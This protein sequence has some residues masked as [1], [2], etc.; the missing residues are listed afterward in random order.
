MGRGAALGGD[1]AGNPVGV[2]AGDIGW[3]DFGHHQHIGLLGFNL[4]LHTTQLRQHAAANIAQVGGALGEQRI[5]QRLLLT[6]RSFDHGH[7]RGR[8]AFALGQAL[9]DIVGQGWVGKH[10]L[11]GDENFANGFV[12]AQDQSLQFAI[13]GSQGFAQFLPLQGARFTPQGIVE[14]T[15]DTDMR[16]AAG[17][18]GGGA[19]TLDTAAGRWRLQYFGYV[20]GNGRDALR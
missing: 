20:I 13:D 11:V 6:G 17:N 18:A 19:H 12:A 4:R 3:T 14:L 9:F 1:N 15:L 7:P 10:F 16:R 8:S 5:V 2:Q